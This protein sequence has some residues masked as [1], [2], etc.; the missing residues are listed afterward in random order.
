[1]IIVIPGYRVD[2]MLIIMAVDFG[3]WMVSAWT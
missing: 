3:F 2:A 1:M